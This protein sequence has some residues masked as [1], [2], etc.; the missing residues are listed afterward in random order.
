M[1]LIIYLDWRLTLSQMK[2]EIK[3][4]F[5]DEQ[6]L[7]MQAQTCPWYAN[8]VNYLVCKKFPP[9]MTSNK[10][11]NFFLKQSTTFGIARSIQIMSR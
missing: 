10:G 7:V 2:D 1:L 8:L 9:D 4:V 6:L 5:S 3:E 11:R